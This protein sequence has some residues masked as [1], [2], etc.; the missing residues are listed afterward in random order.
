M[1][2][3]KTQGPS[4]STL[5]PSQQATSVR[6]Q[7]LAGQKLGS[8]VNTTE[9][10]NLNS[11]RATSGEGEGKSIATNNRPPDSVVKVTQEC[12]FSQNITLTQ[13][14]LNNDNSSY[15]EQPT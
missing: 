12:S 1:E 8:R 15:N 7:E 10:V 13:S 5:S 4:T 6:A 2:L 3:D 11:G 14:H 9:H